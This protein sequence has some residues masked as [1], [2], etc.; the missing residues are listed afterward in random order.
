MAESTRPLPPLRPLAHG[1]WEV[2]SLM[3]STEYTIRG[4]GLVPA[5]HI[6]PV[7]LVPGIMGTNLRA[8]RRPRLSR[9]EDERNKEAKPGEPV[10]RSPNTTWEGLTAATMWD[11]R[12]PKERQLLFDAATLE[13]DEDGPIVVP[14]TDDGYPLSKA[15]LHERGWGEVHAGSYGA[16][17][18][19]LQTRLNQ[20]FSF[21]DARSVRSL[22]QHWRAALALDGRAW[23]GAIPALTEA[24]LDKHARH[25]FPVYACGYNWL[26]DCARSALRLEARINQILAAW[27]TAKRQCDRVILVTHSMGGLVARACAKRIPDQIAGVVHCSMPALGAPVVYR[28]LACG[29][30]GFNPG[31]SLDGHLVNSVIAKVMGRTAEQTTPVLATAPGVLELLPNKRYPRPWLHVRTAFQPGSGVAAGNGKLGRE[32]FTSEGATDHLRLP[33]ARTSNPYD[34]YRDMQSWYRMI[35]PRLADPAGK[36]SQEPDGVVQAIQTALALAE[37]FHDGLGD[38]Y[39]PHSYVIQGADPHKPAYG[40]LRWCARRRSGPNAVLTSSNISGAK[41]VAAGQNGDRRVSVEGKSELHFDLEPQDASG[42]GT[43]PHIPSETFP[44]GVKQVFTGRGYD[45]QDAFNDEG[46]SLLTLRLVASIAQ[47]MS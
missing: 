45:H 46:V 24:Q 7:I 16:L 5:N 41:S 47:G 11:D 10:W 12:S 2:Q 28:R 34:L 21:D 13:P 25:H 29:T 35:D 14:A 37:A 43:V 32:R 6:V 8:R 30:E 36:F 18:H 40:K 9:R 15:E 1:G 26:E 22:R 33:D 19:A 38:Y 44:G 17:L 42:D 3:S 27:K 23:G 20:T 31:N 39:H 4:L